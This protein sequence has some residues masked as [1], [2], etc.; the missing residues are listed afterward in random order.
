M[1]LHIFLQRKY[2]P[3]IQY[4]L[5]IYVKLNYSVVCKV[6]SIRLMYFID[7]PPISSYEMLS[8]LFE[9]LVSVL[10]DEWCVRAKD[11]SVV[12]ARAHSGQPLGDIHFFFL[13]YP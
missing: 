7:L 1:V 10:R 4:H 5:L 6:D 11:E 12:S 9:L 13:M 8:M 3:H 2:I